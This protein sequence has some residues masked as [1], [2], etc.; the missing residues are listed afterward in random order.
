MLLA[1][2]NETSSALEAHLLLADVARRLGREDIAAE[3]QRL[4]LALA[5]IGNDDQA[6]RAA[7]S[8]SAASAAASTAPLVGAAALQR[9]L[10]SRTA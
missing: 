9:A 3:K 6:A 10:P 8:S 4:V 1:Y 5:G 7:A 2:V